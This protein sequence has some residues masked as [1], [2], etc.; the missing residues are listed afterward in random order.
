ML[1]TCTNLTARTINQPDTLTIT[2]PNST[3]SL[4]AVGG[5]ITDPVPYPFNTFSF[6]PNGQTGY[7]Q[8]LPVNERDLSRKSSAWAPHLPSEQWNRLVAAG[9][10]SLVVSGPVTLAVDIKD[11]FVHNL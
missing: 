2:V 5:N 11:S 10:V 9:V 6:A 1:V 7:F 8:T 4:Q 3:A